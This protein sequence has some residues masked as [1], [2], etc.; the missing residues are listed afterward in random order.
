[1]TKPVS[2]RHHKSRWIGDTWILA[3]IM[4]AFL[5]LSRV[6]YP[7]HERF[8]TAN[9][10]EVVY[11]MTAKKDDALRLG[12]FLGPAGDFDGTHKTIRLDFIDG[13]HHVFLIVSE[14]LV[15]SQPAVLERLKQGIRPLCDKVFG[16]EPVTV[17]LTDT[18]LQ[19]HTQLAKL[20]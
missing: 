14:Q 15:E 4:L 12:E 16:D 3:A 6:Q 20:R 13:R 5:G 1:M 10:G 8:I 9:R 18:R 2:L 7:G 19:P 17:W 11:S